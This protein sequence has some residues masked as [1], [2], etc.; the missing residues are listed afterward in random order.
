MDSKRLARVLRAVL[1]G[2]FD[3]DAP[4]HRTSSGIA[5][6]VAGLGA[7]LLVGMLFAP[8]SGETFRSEIGDKA[9][10]GFEKARSKAQD[11]AGRQKNPTSETASAVAEKNAS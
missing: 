3:F 4:S 10:D 11:F 2:D 5:L 6:F 9:R 7:G 8:T 1:A